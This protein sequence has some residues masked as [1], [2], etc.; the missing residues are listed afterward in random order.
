MAFAEAL[1]E[2]INAALA[3]L[4]ANP[5]HNLGLSHRKRIWTAMGPRSQPP[6]GNVIGIGQKRRTVLAIL[7]AKYVAGHWAAAMPDAATPAELTTM[8][9][10]YIDGQQNFDEL[11]HKSHDFWT[12]L[13]ALRGHG[14]PEPAFFAGCASVKSV[15]VAF[16]DE[17]PGYEE[18]N[19]ETWDT[20]LVASL[21]HSQEGILDAAASTQLREQFWRWYLTKAVTTANDIYPAET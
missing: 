15:S 19:I 11:F 14:L 16:R 6:G 1:T 2:G 10:L 17:E 18:D 21:S 8:A 5:H 7:C 3:A 12:Q 9:R 20:A 13:D 4:E